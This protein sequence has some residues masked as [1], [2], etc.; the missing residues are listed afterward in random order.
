MK[1]MCFQRPWIVECVLM[2]WHILKC[3]LSIYKVSSV[4]KLSSTAE[5]PP[6]NAKPS[7]RLEKGK[8]GGGQ[9]GRSLKPQH[10]YLIKLLRWNVQLWNSKPFDEIT[11]S[12]TLL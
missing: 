3:L 4:C 11:M 1:N 5:S 8:G 6:P 9:G 12:S 2:Q 10:L 7:A